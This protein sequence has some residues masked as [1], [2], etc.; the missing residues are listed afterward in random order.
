MTVLQL[1]IGTL[2]KVYG[3]LRAGTAEGW[4]VDDVLY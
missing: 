4:I 3:V 2:K 1:V